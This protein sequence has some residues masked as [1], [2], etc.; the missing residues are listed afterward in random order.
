MT[1]VTSHR[2]FGL[3]DIDH[4]YFASASVS[5]LSLFRTLLPYSVN[6]DEKIFII[7]RSRLH[8]LPFLSSVS[9]RSARNVKTVNWRSIYCYQA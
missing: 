3:A 6:P 7:T 4:L 8:F 1:R 9:I 2:W 5:P